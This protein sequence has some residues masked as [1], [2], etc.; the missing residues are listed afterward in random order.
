ML[1]QHLVP[2]CASINVVGAQK[3]TGA[4]NV[5]GSNSA[6]LSVYLRERFHLLSFMLKQTEQFPAV[7]TEVNQFVTEGEGQ[8]RRETGRFPNG[9]DGFSKIA[10]RLDAVPRLPVSTRLNLFAEHGSCVV[11]VFP[12]LVEVLRVLEGVG[13]QAWHRRWRCQRIR[14]GAG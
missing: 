1:R 3:L 12:H 4:L 13:R 14:S 6:K 8:A 5:L 9:G 2:C 7:S 10:G 11:A